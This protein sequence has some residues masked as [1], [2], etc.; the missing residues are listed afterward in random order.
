[1]ALAIS[2]TGNRPEMATL[3]AILAKSRIAVPTAFWKAQRSLLLLLPMTAMH[4]SREIRRV[5]LQGLGRR[6]REAL[7][8]S[9]QQKT[10]GRAACGNGNVLARRPRT[11]A[12]PPRDDRRRAPSRSKTNGAER[13]IRLPAPRRLSSANGRI[14]ASRSRSATA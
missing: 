1:M 8:D 12:R 13:K 3:V 6:H 7:C 2:P 11:D 10:L 4:V 9:I 5:Y 14:F